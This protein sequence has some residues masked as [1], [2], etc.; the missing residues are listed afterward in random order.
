MHDAIPW[1]QAGTLAGLLRERAARSPQRIAYRYFADDAWQT[2]TW[3]EV[4]ARVGR[5]QAA[6][7]AERLPPGARVAVM[8]P[9]GPDLGVLRPRRGGAGSGHGAR[10]R[11]RPTG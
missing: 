10:L 3:A 5:F 2:L 1:Q 4:A 8:L 9:N 11:R 6:L 7:R